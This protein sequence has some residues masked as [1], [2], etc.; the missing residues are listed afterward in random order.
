LAALDGIS[1]YRLMNVDFEG[2]LGCTTLDCREAISLSTEGGGLDLSETCVSVEF[3]YGGLF[4][5]DFQHLVTCLTR[6][7]KELTEALH[8]ILSHR[9]GM[10]YEWRRAA[11]SLEAEVA[12]HY[13]PRPDI[14]NVDGTSTDNAD[15]EVMSQ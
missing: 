4:G 13:L 2:L 9:H 5:L 8:D 6:T 1:V 7:G 14:W 10:F 3:I 15:R 11:L 12:A